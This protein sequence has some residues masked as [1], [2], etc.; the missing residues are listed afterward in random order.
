M[1]LCKKYLHFVLDDYP[2]TL[3]KSENKAEDPSYPITV[4]SLDAAAAAAA[5]AVVAAASAAAAPPQK[6]R[7]ENQTMEMGGGSK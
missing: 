2:N 4:T 7:L 3:L 1:F 5:A 6:L